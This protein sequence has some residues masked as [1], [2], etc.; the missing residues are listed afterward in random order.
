[1]RCGRAG[2]VDGH[3]EGLACHARVGPVRL[4]HV[5]LVLGKQ[6]IGL[7]LNELAVVE[8]E[9][10]VRVVLLLALDEARRDEPTRP[11]TTARVSAI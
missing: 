3:V 10:Q 6:H 8:V 11:R 5:A 4:Q 1:M 2:H 9:R 7:G